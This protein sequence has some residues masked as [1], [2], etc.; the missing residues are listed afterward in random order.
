MS[1]CPSGKWINNEIYFNV[2]Q[3][4]N[5][6]KEAADRCYVNEPQKNAF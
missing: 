4:R 2:T 6:S 5:K 1:H 3:F